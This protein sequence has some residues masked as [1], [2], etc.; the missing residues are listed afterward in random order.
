MVGARGVGM[1]LLGIALGGAAVAWGAPPARGL[2]LEAEGLAE[3][4][5][6]LQFQVVGGTPGATVYLAVG[7]DERLGATCPAAL[8]GACLDLDAPHLVGTATADAAGEARFTVRV[9]ATFP[10]AS[11]AWFQAASPG[12]T[13]PTVARV[14]LAPSGQR[15]SEVGV[16]GRLNPAPGRSTAVRGWRIRGDDD[17]RDLC[18]YGSE[19]ADVV[20]TLS[21]CPGCDFVFG[22]P[23]SRGS[24]E[25]VDGGSACLD[26]VGVD[27]ASGPRATG[28]VVGLDLDRRRLFT[29]YTDPGGFTVW[30]GYPSPV[31]LDPS[32]RFASAAPRVY[33]GAY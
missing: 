14:S 12:T 13:S 8:A 31:T 15:W 33:W 21:P 24:V 1:G 26:A 25:L 4:G 11:T 23:D 17:A 32:G 6:H 9:P 30:Y 3:P 29:G 27:P 10:P 19:I 7:R 2:G 20:R 16:F 22:S 5:E 28:L 18:V